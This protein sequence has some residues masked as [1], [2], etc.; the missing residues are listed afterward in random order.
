VVLVDDHV[1]MKRT[2]ALA[3]LSRDHHVALVIARELTRAGP[4]QAEAARTRFV[5]FLAEHELTHFALEESVLLPVLPAEAQPELLAN[6]MRHDHEYLRAAM[7]QLQDPQQAAEL[8]FLHEVGARLRAHVQM[9]ERKL[10]PYIERSLDPA[11]LEQI[12]A[13][14]TREHDQDVAEVARRFLT[15]FVARDVDALLALA[16][17]AIE[18]HPLHLTN[19]PAYHG[20]EGVLRWLQDLEPRT[21]HLAFEVHDVRAID[22]EHALAQVRMLFAGEELAA[23]TAILTVTGGSIS[24]VQTMPI[25]ESSASSE[26]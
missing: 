9:E 8:E 3:P 11:A 25:W 2:P 20:H 18:L 22:R 5:R 6:Q 15:A 13:K 23:V 12:G 10:F 21:A 14:L 7:R 4:D 17:P 26:K 1:Q 24:E 19:T 16:D